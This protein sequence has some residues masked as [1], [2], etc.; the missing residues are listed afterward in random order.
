M[1]VCPVKDC[2]AKCYNR[3]RAN[4]KPKETELTD[5]SMFSHKDWV[6]AF[7]IFLATVL[8]S[9]AGIGGGGQATASKRCSGS[10]AQN[11]GA[12]RKTH[13]ANTPLPS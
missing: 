4:L 2:K 13:L 1:L 5:G 11:E 7:G 8:A 3:F 10:H 6:C 12:A 9:A